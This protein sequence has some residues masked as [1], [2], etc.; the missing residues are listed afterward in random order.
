MLHFDL[1]VT[2]QVWNFGNIIELL[3]QYQFNDNVSQANWNF[4]LLRK[5]ERKP[6]YYYALWTLIY[7]CL[8]DQVTSFQKECDKTGRGSVKINKLLK[9][10]MEQIL[11]MELSRLR[12]FSLEKRKLREHVW[13]RWIL[14]YS[15]FYHPTP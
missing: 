13:I 7:L 10:D 8:E 4:E 5:E 12:L 2:V 14:I 1:I 3:Q 6:P 11:C 15:L 9:P